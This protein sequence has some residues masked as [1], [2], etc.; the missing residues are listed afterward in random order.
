MCSSDLE[1]GL[2]SALN[3]LQALDLSNNQLSWPLED[4]QNTF[5]GLHQC[6]TL[7]LANNLIRRLHPQVMVPLP[8]LRQLNLSANP[9][10]WFPQTAVIH[11]QRLDLAVAD[12]TTLICDCKVTW[13]QA[14]LNQQSIRLAA[15]TRHQKHRHP[16]SSTSMPHTSVLCAH[17]PSLAGTPLREV[18]VEDLRCSKELEPPTFAQQPRSQVFLLEGTGRLE[19]SVEGSGNETVEVEWRKNHEE[20]PTHVDGGVQMSR[21][22]GPSQRVTS[23]LELRNVSWADGGRYQCLA[24]TALGVAYSESANVTVHSAPTFVKRPNNV[25]VRLGSN[26]KL[27]CAATG[28]PAPEIG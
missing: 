3:A 19:C 16:T 24:K 15:R 26:A 22:L 7:N 18:D 4:A 2:F 21:S 11:L 9:L 20:L 14:N 5:I 6:K 12:V 8:S 23:I 28:F 25:S 10:T 1:E 13:L 17:P 27:E